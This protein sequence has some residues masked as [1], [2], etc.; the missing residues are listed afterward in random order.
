VAHFLHLPFPLSTAAASFKFISEYLDHSPLRL[1]CRQP[2]NTELQIFIL[3]NDLPETIQPYP[4]RN[5]ATALA[6]A[7]FRYV[8]D[9]SVT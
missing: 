2:S 8:K 6:V 3:G 7:P 9:T 4:Q 1:K 5:G